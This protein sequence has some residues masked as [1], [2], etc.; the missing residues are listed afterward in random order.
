[1]TQRITFGKNLIKKT[2]D[3]EVRI[4]QNRPNDNAY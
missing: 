1:M 4:E 3:D 2:F